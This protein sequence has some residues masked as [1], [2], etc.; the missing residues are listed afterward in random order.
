MEAGTQEEQHAFFFYADLLGTLERVVVAGHVRH[1]SSLIRLGSVDQI[2]MILREYMNIKRL[3]MSLRYSKKS[4]CSSTLCRERQISNLDDSI[5]SFPRA[6]R[7][8]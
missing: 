3:H 1:D 8:K 2:Y 4:N 5:R 7:T 6:Y